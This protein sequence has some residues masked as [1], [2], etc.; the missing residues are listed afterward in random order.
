MGV[1]HCLARVPCL[2]GPG[3]SCVWLCVWALL[4]GVRVASLKWHHMV[5]LGGKLVGVA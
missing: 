2:R 4:R 5:G 3:T 1:V